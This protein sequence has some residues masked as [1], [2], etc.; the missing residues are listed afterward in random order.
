ML[1]NTLMTVI[2]LV[3]CGDNIKPGLPIDEADD[4][5]SDPLEPDQGDGCGDFDIYT[6]C[7]D[8][9]VSVEPDAGDV[10]VV[11][12]PELKGACCHALL[13]GEPPRHDCGYPPGLC[14]NGKKAFFCTL[15]D[16]TDA[17]FTLCS[18]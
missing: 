6:G 9:G 18:P 12:D 10:V 13:N 16:G 11:E 1:K 14:K 17:Q 4:V 8:G 2:L 3:A 15:P 7:P 5:V